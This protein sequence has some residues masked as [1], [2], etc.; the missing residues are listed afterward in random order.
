MTREKVYRVHQDGGGG[1][2]CVNNSSPTL[3][4]CTISGNN[5]G[6]YNQLTNV[7][8]NWMHVRNTILWGNEAPLGKAG[9][10]RGSAGSSILDISYSD[11]EGGQAS[12][13]VDGASTL[14][15]GAGMIDADPLFADAAAADYH[16][17]F[18]SPC[19]S[20]GDRNCPDLPPYDFEK[21]VIIS[22]FVFPEIGADEF[23]T[24]F[25]LKGKVAS[26]ET[27]QGVIVGWPNTSPVMLISG[28]YIRRDPMA[29]PYGEL[30]LGPPWNHR[31]HFLP[32]PA[33]GF[34]VI[35]RVVSTGL[36]WGTEIPVQALVGTE[37]SNLYV[38]VVR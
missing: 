7:T 8:K 33:K 14:N 6:L 15:Y 31:V 24:H 18:D 17:T 28:S 21:D 25:Y 29:T 19:R 11:V 2:L 5:G 4:N 34:R 23:S 3:R 35:E 27:V 22:L 30:W 1:V 13:D 16:I 32:I 36:P 26:G 38:I 9:A 20:A 12:F 37:L 10:L